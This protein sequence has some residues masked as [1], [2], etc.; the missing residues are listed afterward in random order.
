ME[1][2]RRNRV[3]LLIVLLVV[4]V[5][6]LYFR[7]STP[8]AETMRAT[9]NEKGAR[10]VTPS[11]AASSAAPE[12]H[13][14]ALSAERPK[15][16][17]ISR[18]LFQFKTVP[19]APRGGSGSAPAAAAAAPAPVPTGP[20]PPP[21]LPPIALKLTGT[22][23]QGNG[24]RVAFLTDTFGRPIVAREGETVEGRYKVLKVNPSSVDIAYLDGRGQQTIR[25]GQ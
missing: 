23:S 3:V 24:P 17:Q 20:P 1:P 13:L 7:T 14:E 16:D 12:V 19:Q 21:P 15:P 25:R 22:G 10:R 9:S 6:T 2:S 4:L 8:P 11:G 18:N 5:W